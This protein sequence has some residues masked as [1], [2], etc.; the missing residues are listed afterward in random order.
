MKL[1]LLFIFLIHLAVAQPVNNLF[2]LVTRTN[3][4]SN[5][6]P[7]QNKAGSI[8]I[9]TGYV[10][11]V[12]TTFS[13]QSFNVAGGD[14]DPIQSKM[15]LMTGNSTF[16]T[17]NFNTGGIT[18]IPYTTSFSGTTYFDNVSY[19]HSNNTLYGLVRPFGA[20]NVSLGVFFGKLNTTTGQVTTLS[21]NSIA[22]GYQ[23][24]GTIIDPELMVYYFKTGPKFLGID[25]YNGTI[26]SQ[27]DIVYSS[28]DYDFSNFTYNCADNSI[29]GIVREMTT[30]QMPNAPSGVFIQHSR[31]GKIDPATGIVTRVS[32]TIL[33][34]LYYSV[35]AG[36]TIDPSTNTFYCSDNTNLYGI[37]TVTGIAVS[38]TP[39]VFENGNFV[40]FIANTNDCSGATASRL[41]PNLSN[42]TLDLKKNFKIYPNPVSSILTIQS[43]KSIDT[44]EVFDAL[45]RLVL[46]KKSTNTLDVSSLQSGTYLMKIGS[47]NSIESIKFI[48]N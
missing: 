34:N 14:F 44:I 22:S 29:Y 48:K 37:S 21:P 26:Y 36:A 42:T 32:Q 45:G 4:T 27:P 31:L 47:Q 15:Y 13:E 39:L 23:L 43:E 18:T 30:I 7:S 9:N 35:T 33:P 12:S 17:F 3:T 25:L 24:A 16:T 19:S 10:N 40:N 38:T 41:D 46:T 11:D 20:N 8:N 2:T 28:N 6:G 1:N 5:T